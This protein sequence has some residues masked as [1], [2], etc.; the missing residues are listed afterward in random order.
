MSAFTILDSSTTIKKCKKLDEII[1]NDKDTYSEKE[2]IKN[3]IAARQI[4][5]A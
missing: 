4:N 2:N 5:L 1:N 3:E